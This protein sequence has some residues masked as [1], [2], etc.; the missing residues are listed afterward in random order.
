MSTGI[1]VLILTYQHER[2]IEACLRGIAMQ[3]YPGKVEVLIADDA[4]TDNTQQLVKDFIAKYGDRVPGMHFTLLPQKKNLGAAVNFIQAVRQCSQPYLAFCEGDDRWTFPEKLRLQAEVLDANPELSIS[5]TDYSRED[6][7]GQPIAACTLNTRNE[8]YQIADLFTKQG[9]ATNA[10]MMRRSALPTAIPEAFYE[11]PNPDIF[12]FAWALVH[13]HGH[14]T[15]QVCSAYR[16]HGKGIWSSKPQQE[17]ELIRLST[18]IKVLD[19]I[20]MVIGTEMASTLSSLEPALRTAFEKAMWQLAVHGNPLYHKYKNHLSLL[21][22]G[23]FALRC[24]YM[25]LRKGI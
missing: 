11:V 19:H 18:R 15:P 2:Y 22:R 5:F 6:E 21:S 23:H 20:R 12:I 25:Q 3:R 14:Y 10:V 13:G 4:S 7:H 17:Q 8:L 16:V 9:P 24:I 1:S